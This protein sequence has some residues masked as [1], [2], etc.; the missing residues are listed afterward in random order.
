MEL[1]LCRDPE[2][3]LYYRFSPPYPRLLRCRTQSPNPQNQTSKLFITQVLNEFRDK[4][5]S[6]FW[7]QAGDHPEIENQFALNS[8]FPTVILI[9]PNKQLFS[10]MR[11]AFVEKNLEDWIKEVLGRRGARKFNSY[12]KALEFGSVGEEQVEKEERFEAELEE[13]ERER[14]STTEGS[15]SKDG[16]AEEEL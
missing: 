10:V 9:S 8:G 7:A 16:K 12:S 1:V 13:R 5:L 15:T 6:A 14:D 11:S 2:K 3:C 4:P